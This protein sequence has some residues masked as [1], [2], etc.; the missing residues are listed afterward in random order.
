ML[1]LTQN[2]LFK[3]IIKLLFFFLLLS[4]CQNS[5]HG[6][7]I[8]QGKA[9]FSTLDFQNTIY[10]LDGEV[11]L[12]WNQ[13]P[14]NNQ[15]EFN[16]NYLKENENVTFPINWQ[17]K[18]YPA[19]GYATYRMRFTLPKNSPTLMLKIERA[20]TACQ[21]WVNGIKKT[22]IGKIS[23]HQNTAIAHG[24]PIYVELPNTQNIDIV[25]PISNFHHSKGGG[26]PFNIF[27]GSKQKINAKKQL[28][29]TT[30]IG[31]CILIIF[32]S[33]YHIF[34]FLDNRKK[35]SGLY[36]GVFCFLACIRQFA[37]GEV[38]IYDAFPE[39]P[40]RILQIMRYGSLYSSIIFFILY[41]NSILSEDSPKWA[42]KVFTIL[43]SIL[44][45]YVLIMPPFEATYASIKNLNLIIAFLS[46][47]HVLFVITKGL[48][49]KRHLALEIF[50][51]S[52]IA[53]FFLSNDLL[54][55]FNITKTGFIVNFGLLSFILL[56]TIISYKQHKQLEV[57]NLKNF[58]ENKYLKEQVIKNKIEITNI[59]S[60]AVEQ[61]KDKLNLIKKLDVIRKSDDKNS[62]N[63]IVA[64]LKSQKLES[65]RVMVLKQNIEEINFDFIQSLKDKYPNLT[66]S[67]IE[68][69]SLFKLD[70][71]NKMI[72]SLKGITPK[73]LKIYRYRLRKKMGIS[74]DIRLTE[75]I[76]NL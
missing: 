22:E 41:Y 46:I 37:V 34:I 28:S 59:T 26:F 55:L 25:I 50:V 48:I 51:A 11:D 58:Q 72:C 66:K 31:T 38:I 54:F 75:F 62:L 56:Q 42:V 9:D 1:Y 14:F 27:L 76:K 32:I 63:E 64:E 10:S 2:N 13:F 6:P 57:L 7:K 3:S 18:G 47:L 43:N 45:I 20:E 21:V 24:G 16:I 67:D 39:F 49:K 17:K 29:K 74:Q 40:Y 69:C 73:S 71:T 65:E 4:S 53:F 8:K 70:L 44:L 33:L 68:L 19:K 5:S 35:F 15:Q 23:K 60:V 52:M 61:I 12:Y 30:E 36:F